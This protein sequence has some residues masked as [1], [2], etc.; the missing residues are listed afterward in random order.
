[1]AILEPDSK[2]TGKRVNKMDLSI[3]SQQIAKVVLDIIGEIQ[4]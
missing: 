4:V 1:M 3:I 2:K